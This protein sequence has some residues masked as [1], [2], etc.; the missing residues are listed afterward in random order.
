MV[1]FNIDA[2]KGGSV[3]LWRM[4]YVLFEP[5]FIILFNYVSNNYL[6]QQSFKR[7]FNNTIHSTSNFVVLLAKLHLISKSINVKWVATKMTWKI[8]GRLEGKQSQD[9]VVT[10]INVASS[11]I[12]NLWKQFK[13]TGPTLGR[14]GYSLKT[15]LLPWIEN[16]AASA[17]SHQFSNE[18]LHC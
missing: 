17:G 7:F 8:V 11:V 9:L 13:N 15:A 4:E 3:A 2:F 10:E 12:Y 5:K 16:C 18:W 1:S 14:P 6:N